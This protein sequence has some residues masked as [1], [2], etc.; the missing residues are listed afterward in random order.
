MDI[1]SL[2]PIIPWPPQTLD[3]NPVYTEE[4]LREYEQH[5]ANE[6]NDINMKSAKLQKQREQL[7]KQQE[8][9]NAQKLELQQV[10]SKKQQQLFAGEIQSGIQIFYP[11]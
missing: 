9:L 4:E 8:E 7:E 1:N 3:Q 5:L 2:H 6:A 11:Q 10:D